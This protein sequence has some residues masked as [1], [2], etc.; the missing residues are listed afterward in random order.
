M[1]RRKRSNE[2]LWWI[3]F[4]GGMMVD[5]LAMP[6][7]ILITGFLVPIGLVSPDHLRAIIDHP[8]GRLVML[9]VIA[10]TFFNA[11]H[12]L[13]FVIPDLGFRALSPILPFLCYGGAIAGTLAAI[14]IA[15]RL[16]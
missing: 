2:P 6:A 5:A 15:F 1:M 7:L 14:G 13:R 9:V 3:P 8:L 4:A 16:F 11:A 10:M 12:R